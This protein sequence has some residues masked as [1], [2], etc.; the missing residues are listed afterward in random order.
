MT[1]EIESE[2]LAKEASVSTESQ[3]KM[4]LYLKT[5]LTLSALFLLIAGLINWAVDPLWYGKGNRLTGRNFSFNERI[6]KTNHFLQS[7]DKAKYD[8][9]IFGSSRV[10]LLRASS[11]QKNR[12]FNYSFSAG[13]IEEF[14]QYAQYVKA[15]GVN[16]KIVYVGVDAFNFEKSNSSVSKKIEPQSIYQAYFSW[17]VLVFSSKTILGLSP[18]PRYYNQKFESEVIENLPEFKPKFLER[19]RRGVCDTAKIK[20]YKELQEIFPEAGFVGYVP[21]L[22]AWNF[23]NDIYARDLMDCYLQSVHQ[24]SKSYDVMYDFSAPSSVTA[25]AENTYDGDHFYPEVQE[26]ISK[27]LQGKPSN[28]GIR[29]DRFS[30]AEYENFYRKSVKAFLVTKGYEPLRSATKRPSPIK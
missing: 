23:F 27:V 7:K 4:A 21:P 17:D 3:K 24:I 5:Y 28:F 26:K 20:L 16:P 12:C 10:T 22:S 19:N 14:V 29:V 30:L 8:C 2:S 25:D 13:R 15:K 18:D 1:L 9:L 6:S 11:F